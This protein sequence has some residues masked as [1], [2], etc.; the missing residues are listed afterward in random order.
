MNKKPVYPP[1]YRTRMVYPDDKKNITDDKTKPG[2]NHENSDTAVACE[3]DNEDTDDEDTGLAETD[4]NEEDSDVD[5]E[6][7]ESSCK[8]WL[9]VLPSKGGLLLAVLIT[10]IMTEGMTPSQMNILG[11]FVS[12]IGSLIAYK[13]SRDEL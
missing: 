3:K 2:A 8:M 11:N 13:A 7:E 1:G 6:D 4:E 9:E 5:E 10:E 12:A